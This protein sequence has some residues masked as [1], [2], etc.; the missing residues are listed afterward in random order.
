MKL[1]KLIQEAKDM[2]L[3]AESVGIRKAAA[4]LIAAYEKKP[5]S[6]RDK[7]AKDADADHLEATAA[8]LPG[9]AKL[10]LLKRAREVRDAN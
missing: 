3:S 5:K 2:D 4:D 7:A 1:D 8:I 6:E 9:W 10:K